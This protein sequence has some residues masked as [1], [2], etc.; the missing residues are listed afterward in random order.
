MSIPNSPSFSLNDVRVELSGSNPFSLST[1]FGNAT[2]AYF[3][4]TYSGSKDRLSNFRNYKPNINVGNSDILFVQDLGPYLKRFN[5]AAKTNTELINFP[6]S[7]SG[8]KGTMTSNKLWYSADGTNVVENDITLTPFEAVR[9]RIITFSTVGV[10]VIAAISNTLLI[11][12]VVNK[13]Y[14]ADITTTTPVLTLKYTLPSGASFTSL[15]Y[16]NGGKVIASTRDFTGPVTSIMQFNYSNWAVEL[17]FVV[18]GWSTS[19]SDILWSVFYSNS[20]MYV[21][22]SGG[23]CY[24]IL[25]SPP[26]TT[27]FYHDTNTYISNF[28]QQVSSFTGEFSATLPIPADVTGVVATQFGILGP[29]IIVTWNTAA[30]ATSYHIWVQRNG[31]TWSDKGTIGGT[32]YTD[33]NTLYGLEYCYRIKGVNASGESVNY[34]NIDCETPTN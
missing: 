17:E 10:E 7:P 6:N 5:V 1:A 12:S 27:T 14:T 29:D 20:T 33:T 9:N 28:F 16:T 11:V 26:Y 25:T 22:A 30:D 18:P 15:H 23:D 4:G 21:A 8:N 13:I 3:D 19:G 24:S 34:S 2:A 32:L 31:G